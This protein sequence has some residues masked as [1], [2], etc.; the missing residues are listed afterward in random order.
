LN[1]T[2]KG[3]IAVVS[4]NV[5]PNRPKTADNGKPACRLCPA[6]LG[7]AMALNPAA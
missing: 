2:K 7:Q 5:G 3:T 1:W 4:K 6:T